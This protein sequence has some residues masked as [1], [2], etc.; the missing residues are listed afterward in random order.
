MNWMTQNT[1]QQSASVVA[2]ARAITQ[3]FPQNQQ[4]WKN[5]AEATLQ[6]GDVAGAVALLEDTCARFPDSAAFQLQLS[7]LQTRANNPEA[8]VAASRRACELA[9]DSAEARAAL[10]T[11]LNLAR[12][13]DE[14]ETL[15]QEVAPTAQNAFTRLNIVLHRD[16]AWP[17]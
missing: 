12:R 11:T 6:A 7:A 13:F 3:A 17:E 9:P 15:L 2:A 14:A 10:L 4:A 16:E 8:A 5:L 1:G